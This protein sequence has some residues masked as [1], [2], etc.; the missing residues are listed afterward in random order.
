MR[1]SVGESILKWGY[2]L[3]VKNIFKDFRLIFHKYLHPG[4]SVMVDRKKLRRQ[5]VLHS[6]F[7]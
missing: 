6:V 2:V 5:S 1:C 7:G 3:F 4:F